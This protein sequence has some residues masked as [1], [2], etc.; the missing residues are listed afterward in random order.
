[1]KGCQAV[2]KIIAGEETAMSSEYTLGALSSMCL[3]C[4]FIC[5]L[6]VEVVWDLECVLLGSHMHKMEVSYGRLEMLHKSK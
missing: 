6:K 4:L 5:L 1:M 2:L 3:I